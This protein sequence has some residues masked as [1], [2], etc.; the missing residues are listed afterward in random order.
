M[1]KETMKIVVVSL[2]LLV[3][4][5][6]LAFIVSRLVKK[7]VEKRRLRAEERIKEMSETAEGREVLNEENQEASE[8]Q[9]KALKAAAI[10]YLVV[11]GLFIIAGITS[12][13][14][15]IHK[16]RAGKKVL[17]IIGSDRG[18]YVLAPVAMLWSIYSLLK[19]VVK[20]RNK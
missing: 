17:E 7:A 15:F 14:I 3:F 2:V 5:L 4:V 20:G 10:G 1:D 19:L 18:F 11:Y 13:I 16:L 9:S 8:K 12:I 6:A